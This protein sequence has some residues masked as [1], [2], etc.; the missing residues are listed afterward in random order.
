MPEEPIYDPIEVAVQEYLST[1]TYFQKTMRK[2]GLVDYSY[3][4]RKAWTMVMKTYILDFIL[5]KLPNN[6]EEALPASKIRERM[7]GE[8]DKSNLSK[9]LL[10]LVKLGFADA[11]DETE[12]PLYK[13]TWVG[14][15]FVLHA[16]Y[17]YMPRTEIQDAL[18]DAESKLVQKD[19]YIQQL[20][21][22]NAKFK[23][24]VQ[25]LRDEVEHIK[26]KTQ[27]K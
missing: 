17:V 16:G 4:Q 2:M 14:D 19:I 15:Y 8:Y 26:L 18:T 12:R 10:S 7:G 1:D 13:R 5:K 25:A 9:Y 20:E 24:E 6:D 27:S 23:A 3:T 11:N 22:E 21:E